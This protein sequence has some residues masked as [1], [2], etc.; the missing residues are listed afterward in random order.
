MYTFT[1]TLIWSISVHGTDKAS[2]EL[3]TL[4][5]SSLYCIRY[6]HTQPCLTHLTLPEWRE[7]FINFLEQYKWS[8]P[9][10]LYQCLITLAPLLSPASSHTIFLYHTCFV[11]NDVVS[12]PKICHVHSSVCTCNCIYLNYLLVY[13]L[14]IILLS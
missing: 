14:L 3:L 6:W 1:C 5:N 10:A 8:T 12:F 9:P 7:I 13:S 4:L 2:L 11:H